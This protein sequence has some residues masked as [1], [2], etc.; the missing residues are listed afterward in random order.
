MRTTLTATA[1]LGALTFASPALSAVVR[2]CDGTTEAAFNIVEPWETSSRT[3]YQGR[4]RVAWLDT[5]GEPAC[6]SAHLLIVF[7]C[8]DD[9]EG[10][11]CRLISDQEARGFAAIDFK[12]LK[13]SYDP[14]RGLLLTFGYS[15]FP[16]GEDGSGA[17]R[18]VA[19]VRIN[20]PAGTVAVER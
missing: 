13:S 20:V 18:G 19:K 4:V 16:L 6:C 5:G 2:D 10:F 7:Y 8:D 15:R 17:E 1:L 9:P 11:T 3:F 14:A 12:S